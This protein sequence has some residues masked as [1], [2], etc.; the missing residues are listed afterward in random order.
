MKYCP[1]IL[2]PINCRISKISIP[3]KESYN[4]NPS[5]SNCY[6]TI[7]KDE[8][9]HLSKPRIWIQIKT[10]AGVEKCGRLTRVMQSISSM[11]DGDSVQ[12]ATEKK[13]SPRGRWAIIG[14]T[15][16]SAAGVVAPLE[17][18]TLKKRC[19]YD[20]RSDREEGELN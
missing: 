20:G 14:S 1:E 12:P 8:R 13:L 17:G 7:P 16:S 18:W 2:D 4:R 15:T 5:T 6:E 9:R 3:R 11:I 19:V 10:E